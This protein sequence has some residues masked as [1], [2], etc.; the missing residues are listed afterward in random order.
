MT[1]GTRGTGAKNKNVFEECNIKKAILTANTDGF[2]ADLRKA[3]VVEYQESMFS[4][5]IDVS[6]IITSSSSGV[7]GKNL[8]EG[9]PLVGTEDFNLAIEDANGNVIESELVVNKVTPIESTT[10][11]ESIMLEFTS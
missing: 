10:Q 1:R 5:T 2:E 3:S 8:M 4:D 9:L 7:R 6:L 11:K